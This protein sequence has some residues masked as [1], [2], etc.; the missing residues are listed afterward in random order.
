MDEHAWAE[1]RKDAEQVIEDVAAGLADVG[2]VNEE[3]VAGGELGEERER[4]VLQALAQQALAI[5]RIGAKQFERQQLM[6]KEV[7]FR[8]DAAFAKPEVYEALEERSVKYAIRMPA[9]NILQQD[10]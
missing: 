2:G 8:A 5:L 4:G 9:N 1:A 6:G 3:H 7:A 10:I